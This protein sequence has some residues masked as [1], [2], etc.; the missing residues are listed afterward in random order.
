MSPTFFAQQPLKINQE[1]L[2][3]EDAKT[4][5]PVIIV[6]DSTGYRGFNFETR[7]KTEFPK[8][9]QLS[10]FNDYQFQI[11]GVT[12]FA[13]NGCGI[14]LAFKNNTFTRIDNSFS[15]KNQYSAI[16]FVHDNKPHLFSGYGLFT[17]KNIITYYDFVTN[18]W[19]L[20]Q[21]SNVESITPRSS[22]F[23]LKKDVNL[24]VID[25]LSRRDHVL[26]E[27]IRRLDLNT[28]R[29]HKEK[30]I[31]KNIPLFNI[32]YQH[33]NRLQIDDKIVSFY[34]KIVEVDIFNNFIKTFDYSIFKNIEAIKYFQRSKMLTYVY[35]SN[36]N[37]YIISE[38]YT[39][40]K[41][42]LISEM[43]LYVSE[44]Y[45][46]F[47][48]G[49][50]IVVFAFAF[51]YGFYKL[52]V[53]YK[54]KKGQLLYSVTKD[55]FFV[56]KKN[57]LQLSPLNKA[58]LK[59]FLAQKGSFFALHSLNDALSEDLN[60]DN[61]VT[62]NKRRERVLKD[63]KFELSNVLKMPKESVFST[64]SSQLDKRMKEIKINIIFREV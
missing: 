25:Y 33:N 2:L 37:Y 43:P 49:F 26:D 44:S 52:Y 1:Y 61:Y 38:P 56:N 50:F 45:S 34:D 7:F 11:D 39:S 10:L 32:T 6:N 46:I 19:L 22:P 3:F 59:V 30:R 29:W 15:H 12:Y 20:K 57:P 48:Y 28:F 55:L 8:P 42:K 62:I 36:Q 35:Q 58:V 41:S 60:E 24:Y 40:L 31:N 16:P 5:E 14:T 18:E 23:F 9:F 51:C 21:T 64:R 13:E 4:K 53:S 17:E 27:Y 54:I 63:L 47:L